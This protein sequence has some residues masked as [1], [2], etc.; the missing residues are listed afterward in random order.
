MSTTLFQLAEREYTL[1]RYPAKFQHKSL[2]AWDSADQ[3]LLEHILAIPPAEPPPSI[4]LLNDE[5]GALACVLADVFPDMTLYSQSDSW[6][7]HKATQQ[8]LRNNDITADINFIDSMHSLQPNTLVVV[9]IPRTLSYLEWQLNSVREYCESQTQVI[10]AAKVTALTPSIFKLFERYLGPVTTSLAKKKSRLLFCQ[11]T[12][13]KVAASAY[14]TTFTTDASETGVALTLV[15]HA[16]VFSRQSLDIGARVM[17]QHLPDITSSEP[18]RVV[19]LGCGNG[20]LG[21]ALLAQ[22][23]NAYV[24]FVD[25]SFMALASAKA[26]I[27]ENLPDAIERSQFV[28][29]NCLEAM[30]EAQRNQ[31]DVVVCNPPFH[32]QNVVTEHIAKQ[33]FKDAH[34][35]LKRGG[36]LR[37]VANRHLPYGNEL[38]RIFGGFRV[39]ASERKFVILSAIKK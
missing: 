32:Q 27:E 34:K 37:V 25:D 10:A 35:Y 31:I 16:N 26:S 20:V 36:E 15:N 23:D 12:Q 9:K 13:P 1:Y 38:K 28:A 7:S 4:T 30:D 6:I 39:L 24:T 11:N 18:T 17:L 33:M 2:Q 3:L 29:S 14:P 19:D 22:H 5:F 21:I 8:N